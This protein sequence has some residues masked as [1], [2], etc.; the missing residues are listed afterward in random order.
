M[1]F[2]EK[3][4]MMKRRGILLVL[5]AALILWSFAGGDADR[6]FATPP[7]P[8]KGLVWKSVPVGISP[9]LVGRW[10]GEG[11][12]DRTI[13]TL[14]NPTRNEQ[15]ALII[16]YDTDE[17]F[18]ACDIRSLSRHDIES[19]SPPKIDFFGNSMTKPKSGSFEVVSSAAFYVQP[20]TLQVTLGS[21]WG[22]TV[23]TY[24]LTENLFNGLL[25]DVNLK[26]KDKNLI[27][28]HQI[29]YF[30]F[31]PPE[32]AMYEPEPYNGNFEDCVCDRLDDLWLNADTF[33]F[34]YGVDCVVE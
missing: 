5:V 29:N 16:Y 28:L 19:F 12:S 4:I 2:C 31:T 20:E 32:A 7:G 8:P 11:D 9:F 34:I 22:S 27:D 24:L 21:S 23:S 26:G 33:N 30:Y 10:F 15:H 14:Q 6:A 18:L 13:I 17:N 1:E 3:E 25:G